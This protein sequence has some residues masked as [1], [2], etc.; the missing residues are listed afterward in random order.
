M[1]IE[2]VPL[3]GIG[4]RLRFATTSGTWVGVIQHTDGH[5][6]LLVYA[7]SDSDT[8]QTSVRLTEQEA[9]ELSEILYS[10]HNG[11]E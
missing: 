7:A 5:R 4:T 2:R 8:V 10:H 3:P 6:E 1:R 9:H 11:E